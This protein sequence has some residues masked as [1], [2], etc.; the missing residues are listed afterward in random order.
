MDAAM[1]SH[2]L[3]LTERQSYSLAKSPASIFL[4]CPQLCYG[5]DPSLLQCQAVIYQLAFEEAQRVVRPSLPERD[6]LG[7][8][9]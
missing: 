5:L 1:E 6:L 2:R 7:Y 9:N 3:S 4:L 8:W